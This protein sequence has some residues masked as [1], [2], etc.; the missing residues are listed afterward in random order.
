M[1]SNPLVTVLMPTYK[2]AKYLR[3]TIDSVLNQTFKD[4]EFLIIND[5]S[6]DDTDEII[7]EYDDSRIRYV[8]NEKNLGISG[9]SNYGFSIARGKYIARQDHDDI[10]LPDR[11][12][13]QVDYL[14]SHPETG[15]VGTGFRVFGSKSK[16]VIYPENDAEIK[17]LLLFKMP[18]AHQTSMMRKSVFVD[19]GLRYDESFASSNDRK[20]WIEAMD[21]MA[22]HN[23]Q[24]PLLRYRMYKGMTSVTKRDRVLEEG[25]R[26]RDLLFAK[27][28][29]RFTDAEKAIIDTYLMQG[30]AHLKDVTILEVIE[31][32]LQ[33]LVKSNQERKV[34]ETKAFEKVC[35][36]YWF[37]RCLNCSF[38]GCRST[39]AI[40][41]KSSLSKTN[42]D[43]GV[44]PKAAFR[45]VNSLFCWR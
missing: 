44:V 38:Y 40:F 7:A 17:A 30:R 20:L 37:K 41:Q 22:F 28:G 31:R 11:L 42:I 29:V 39:A 34:F 23:L 8:K 19:N 36:S 25:K 5:C 24:E 45:I 9:S 13:K 26:M 6:P 21:H 32:V 16:T 12:Q 35:A 14:E 3:E 43:E 4:F 27:L 10:S 2:G 1:S 18:L 33:K 15:L